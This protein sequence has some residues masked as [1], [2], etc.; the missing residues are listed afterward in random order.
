MTGKDGAE[1]RTPDT[2]STEEG[3][4]WVSV[5]I[6]DSFEAHKVVV[7]D[8]CVRQ[9]A[10]VREFVQHQPRSIRLLWGG[11]FRVEKASAANLA[12]GLVA[13]SVKYRSIYRKFV[14]RLWNTEHKP[15]YESVRS[16]AICG[17]LVEQQR[18]GA[19][20][21]SSLA[22]RYQPT[23]TDL[24]AAM[25]FVR[26]DE[27]SLCSPG[28][29]NSVS[30]RVGDTAMADGGQRIL[31]ATRATP[32]A[33]H[34]RNAVREIA[35]EWLA[36]PSDPSTV[37]AIRGGDS[38]SLATIETVEKNVAH[39]AMDRSVRQFLAGNLDGAL[40]QVPSFRDHGD[41]GR[42][43]AL[44]VEML[45]H[46]A[47]GEMEACA[48]IFSQFLVTDLR[49]SFRTWPCWYTLGGAALLE[50]GRWAEAARAFLIEGGG[51]CERAIAPVQLASEALAAGGIDRGPLMGAA[52]TQGWATAKQRQ[53]CAEELEG[54]LAPNGA[55]SIPAQQ[56][57]GET[58]EAGRGDAS[59]GA[60]AWI[61]EEIKDGTESSPD[62]V[63]QAEQGESG[64][65]V[66]AV[67]S[68]GTEAEPS[69]NSAGSE[70]LAATPAALAALPDPVDTLSGSAAAALRALR[71]AFHQLAA[72]KERRMAAVAREDVNEERSL[73]IEQ[74]RLKELVDVGEVAVRSELAPLA[75]ELPPLPVPLEDR[76]RW[77]RAAAD[78][79]VR[80]EG[81]VRE[82]FER[83]RAGLVE[84]CRGLNLAVPPALLAAASREELVAAGT[85]LAPVLLKERAY[86]R[87]RDSA[88][89]G[90]VPELPDLGAAERVG[91]YQRLAAE[92]HPAWS[93]ERLLRLWIADQTVWPHLELV[94]RITTP[95]FRIL[96]DAAEPL[97][98]GA[99]PFWRRLWGDSA[100]SALAELDADGL[101]DLL[102][103]DPASRDSLRTAMAGV[104]ELPIPIER[105]FA[106]QDAE[107][108]ASGER[109]KTVVALLR[110][111]PGWEPA[112]RSLVEATL[113]AGK[114]GEALALARV[115]VH[116]GWLLDAD[117]RYR[118]ALF[119]C[120]LRHPGR[121][122]DEAVAEFQNASDLL[123][124][125][126]D[127]L[128]LLAGAARHDLYEEIPYWAQSLRERAERRWPVSTALLRSAVE[129]PERI[130]RDR[131]VASRA[132]QAQSD[133]EKGQ[134][135]PS[136]F[137]SWAPSKDY[138]RHFT[139]VLA[140]YRRDVEQG[141]P[142]PDDD[143]ETIIDETAVK[144]GLT[145]AEGKGRQA[146]RLHLVGQLQCLVTLAEGV[147]TF[148]S[149]KALQDAIAREQGLGD[150]LERMTAFATK[151]PILNV[152]REQVEA[153]HK[154]STVEAA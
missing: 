57:P 16:S 108:T 26:Q 151:R 115:G 74:G 89:T 121:L 97:P 54:L 125:E 150:E 116:Q 43:G 2:S 45:I 53:A 133:F 35:M 138:Q 88:D 40:A 152:L 4:E 147:R 130:V 48:A 111:Y 61:G 12:R 101:A 126:F 33:P 46:F 106:L 8:L 117:R 144:H 7:R 134:H 107:R 114:W 19:L 110:R 128:L 30:V 79:F 120:L 18:L 143:P 3:T 66:E 64:E 65:I 34:L 10:A 100:G 86:Q 124:D 56:E 137:G 11:G 32:L 85:S 109:L 80:H 20:A 87:L 47:R 135:K 15:L 70:A 140:R 153:L 62:E 146:M 21:V 91:L 52:L 68:D 145:E 95:L 67:A 103:S 113:A 25:H 71:D 37:A 149:W 50:V 51:R 6:L 105:I 118:D 154:E 127:L 9:S 139:E 90:T 93:A 84:E 72:V 42:A 77:L 141:R 142:A 59:T 81:E 129:A 98:A 49:P 75:P 99:W 44:A 58:I 41:T 39:A 63:D 36:V 24:A 83:R 38:V 112:R 13:A 23:L 14:V 22:K 76:L 29:W 27:P 104:T 148:S 94:R 17:H 73:Q 92:N 78:F 136:L 122:N 31:A 28:A 55:V 60:N 5:P 123:T 132:Q 69:T 1:S 96:I 102:E 119:W 131:R 82:R